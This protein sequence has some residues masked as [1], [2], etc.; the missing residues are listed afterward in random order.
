M[1]QSIPSHWQYLQWS[2]VVFPKK[3]FEKLKYCQ[4]HLC[5]YLKFF[6]WPKLGPLLAYMYMQVG[7]YHYPQYTYRY[8]IYVLPFIL[9]TALGRGLVPY[10]KMIHLLSGSI[11]TGQS[12]YISSLFQRP[13]RQDSGPSFFWKVSSL[14]FHSYIIRWVLSASH[15]ALMPVSGKTFSLEVVIHVPW[16]R[17][18]GILFF[19]RI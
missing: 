18:L 16:L 1:P 19:L 6:L 4:R 5:L 17:S 7:Q 13:L 3:I 9:M 10:S 14:P 11:P 2:S 15:I 12:A 8:K